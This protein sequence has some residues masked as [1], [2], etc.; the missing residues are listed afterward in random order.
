MNAEEMNNIL[1]DAMEKVATA[2][3]EA[4]PYDRTVRATI[5][6]CEDESIAKYKVRYQDAIFYAYGSTSNV[7]FS[8]GTEVYVLIPNG[9]SAGNRT[10]LGSVEKLGTNYVSMVNNDVLYIPVGSNAINTSASFSLS[11]Y[12]TEEVILYR[13]VPVNE[14]D[15]KL[16]IDNDLLKKSLADTEYIRIGANFT[17]SIEQKQQGGT[18]NFGIR[19]KIKLLKNDGSRERGIDD[20]NCIS[21]DYYI[22]DI[23][24]L[25]NNPYSL[26]D[27]TQNKEFEI[28]GKNFLEIEEVAIF[29]RDF[30]YQDSESII[31]DIS[32]GNI[33][34]LAIKKIDEA[35]T[36][37]AW[38][39]ITAPAGPYFDSTHQAESSKKLETTVY[40]GGKVVNP[41]S[42]KIDY[43]WFVEDVRVNSKWE[44]KDFYKTHYCSF[45]G[46]GWKCLN[47]YNI[48]K[49]KEENDPEVIEWVSGDSYLTIK[50]QDVAAKE[51][52]Y[53][54]V[55]VYNN[56][57]LNYEILVHNYSSPY[58]V[59]VTS[60]SGD[61]F[62]FSSGMTDL[63]CTVTSTPSGIIKYIWGLVDYRKNEYYFPNGGY[64]LT[65][66]KVR[67]N[68]IKE[69]PIAEITPSSSSIYKCSVFK[70]NETL[71]TQDKYQLL[72]IGSITLTNSS[73]KTGQHTLIIKDGSQV[74]KYNENGVAPNENPDGTPFMPE[75]LSFILYDTMGKEIEHRFLNNEFYWFLPME[76]TLLE[77]PGW[78]DYP[79][80]EE[81]TIDDQ[82]YIKVKGREPL[83][84]TIAKRYNCNYTNNTIQ[85]EVHYQ[86]AVF[87]SA[88]NFS[89][90]KEGEDGTNGTD[91]YF[92]I[93]PNLK[94]YSGYPLLAVASKEGATNNLK[95]YSNG[96]YLQGYSLYDAVKGDFLTTEL[97]ENGKDI[98]DE[99]KIAIENGNAELKWEVLKNNYKKEVNENNRSVEVKFTDPS[100]L[101]YAKGSENQ[102]DN[103][104]FWQRRT[105]GENNLT[106]SVDLWYILG[107]GSNWFNGNPSINGQINSS[108]LVIKA[109]LT[110]NNTT[111]LATYPLNWL[112][113]NPNYSNY[114]FNIK[115][116]CK[117]IV[118]ASDG[119][120][121]QYA[122]D[123]FRVHVY[124]KVGDET[125][126]DTDNCTYEWDVYGYLNVLEKDREEDRSTWR[127]IDEKQE[128]FFYQA[129]TIKNG[130]IDEEIKGSQ[131]ISPPNSYNGHCVNYI[132]QCIIKKGSHVI[133]VL[134]MPIHMMLNRYGHAALNSWDGNSISIDANGNG[135]ILAPQVG[136][137]RKEEDNSFT[138][139]LMRRGKRGKS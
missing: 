126:E 127:W 3:V 131:I 9:N 121:P 32:I 109:T 41:N 59:E 118:Y 22:I 44:D 136:A 63:A 87:K 6:S 102:T 120:R 56:L 132:V 75:P 34:A 10:I 42:Q 11:S 114:T 25:S 84:Y 24:D 86:G 66:G 14:D 12:K 69:L 61:L 133:A 36:G 70:Y 16:I 55:A 97:W 37:G 98:T 4:A 91:Y 74:F 39:V 49:G 119:T 48:I 111:F 18:G 78:A 72:G 85:L 106:T 82:L 107:D 108:A 116:G 23:N 92:R 93:V 101:K 128:G 112:I 20:A 83:S 105:L 1:Y 77:F 110:Y 135:V 89:F 7:T 45:G 58:T 33:Q 99:V 40:V 5:L 88:T 96:Q 68:E 28:D 46:D 2:A 125:I 73:E 134:Q 115:G 104:M 38:M 81:V 123:P 90:I 15:N 137:G 43:Y 80:K 67:G 52:R 122:T 138:G 62:Y 54:C 53:K 26:S 95:F 79:D 94:D 8:A 31:Q 50:K 103:K 51:I 35:S 64:T 129:D 13:K 65:S 130:T 27:L 124:K 60:T 21:R 19:F 17:T 100:Y 57:K 47:D 71:P 30:P 29:S 113:L 117:Y 139:V 76:N